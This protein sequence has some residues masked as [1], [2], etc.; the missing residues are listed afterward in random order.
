MVGTEHVTADEQ[1]RLYSEIIQRNV[2]RWG[3]D[4]HKIAKLGPTLHG[5]GII[6]LIGELVQNAED[7]RAK[8]IGFQALDAGLVVWNDGRC[9]SE[10]DV[11]AISGLLVTTKDARHIGHF[12]IGF[13]SVLLLTNCPH[14]LSG[15][16]RFSLKWALDPEGLDDSQ[17][18]SLPQEVRSLYQQGYTVFWLP[19][20]QEQPERLSGMSSLVKDK[21]GEMLLFLDSLEKITCIDRERSVSLIA[22]RL[23]FAPETYEVSIV[24]DGQ[25]K[26]TWL[27]MDWK[28]SLPEPVVKRI[29][30]QLRQED[31][32]ESAER[33]ER[34]IGT[35]QLFS[36]AIKLNDGQ[37]EPE[38][39]RV[40]VRL[41]TQQTTGLKF[42]LCGR[43]AV[44]LDR[45]GIREDDFL[46]DWA[47]EQSREV[48]RVLP[49]RLRSA[50]WFLPTMWAV[51]PCHGEVKGAFQSLEE[52]LRYELQN[53]LYYPDDLNH[54]RH[55][56]E[57]FLAH[58]SDLYELLGS[59]ELSEI[60]GVTGAR[61]V[62]PELRRGRCR[63]VI[64]NFGVQEIK[65][66]QVLNWLKTKEGK[67]FAEKGSGWLS[68]LYTYL[69]SL[70]SEDVEGVSKL[71][72]VPLQGGGV[73]EPINAF[74][75]PQDPPEP[76]RPWLKDLPIV[77]EDVIKD[78]ETREALRRLGVREF[79]VE[80]V[81]KHLIRQT[82]RDRTKPSSEE[83]RRH[84]RMLFSLWKEGRL[85]EGTLKDLSDVEFL[86]T[87]QGD[88]IA[89]KNAYLP[90]SLGGLPEVERFLSLYEEV[91]FVTDD[92]REEEDDEDDWRKFLEALGVARLPRCYFVEEFSGNWSD[93]RRWLS[94][95]VPRREVSYSTRGYSGWDWHIEGF[96]QV[97]EYLRE[98]RK[99]GTYDEDGIQWVRSLW[100]VMA[101]LLAE[102][103]RSWP[104]LTEARLKWFYRT[105]QEDDITS[106]WLHL[107]RTELWLPDEAGV[108]AKPSELI[109]PSL[110]RILG[111]GL[112]YLHREIPLQG[113]NSE[114][115]AKHLG[116]HITADL[117][118]VLNYL[119]QLAWKG[120]ME[121]SAVQ[122]VYKWLAGRGET[123]KQRLREVFAKE[124]L[125]L[126][127]GK[128]WFTASEVCWRDPTGVIPDLVDPWAEFKSFFVDTLGVRES[129][130]VAHLARFLLSLPER[131]TSPDLDM[132]REI[133]KRLADGWEKL[134]D[135]LKEALSR[136]CWLG[137]RGGNFEWCTLDR[138]FLRDK[139]WLANL[140]EGKVAWW[141]L[142]GLESLAERL[143]VLKVSTAKPVFN[144]KG[145]PQ[146]ANSDL[147]SQFVSVWR[148]IERFAQ[149]EN[150]QPPQVMIVDGISVRYSLPGFIWS[151]AEEDEAYLDENKWIL[152]VAKDA[153]SDPAHPIGDVLEK[154]LGRAGLR[155]FV[156][157]VWTAIG[158][159]QRLKKVLERWEREGGCKLL[160]LLEEVSGE[161]PHPVSSTEEETYPPKE[162]SSLS[163]PARPQERLTTPTVPSTHPSAGRRE[164]GGIRSHPT[165]SS[166]SHPSGGSGSPHEEPPPIPSYEV[167]KKAMEK[168]KEWWGQKGY[169]VEDVSGHGVGFDL[170]VWKD[171]HEFY[172]EVKGLSQPGSITMTE[173]EWEVARQRREKYFLMV[174]VLGEGKLYLIQN[175]V[176][177]L[178]VRENIRVSKE[179]V[180]DSWQEV[181]DDLEADI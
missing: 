102:H 35:H 36:I 44:K 52:P 137:R 145:S 16:F 38:E 157:D 154:V 15:N 103:E 131:S 26:E 127:Q 1:N 54:L 12:G 160:D 6:G 92:Y 93:A 144:P 148:F 72:M 173:N 155:E 126:V 97:I 18:E 74:F 150:K 77:A 58:R 69:A 146:P 114:N 73:S 27:R 143:G 79:Q 134:P 138:L 142:D 158:K 10:D 62:H 61:W 5:V 128:G 172:V 23:S 122:F 167:A 124:R 106:Y 50:G 136:S 147:S 125:I 175:P 179:Y 115:L 162:T 3:K 24:V 30:H 83:N 71:P 55:R 13:K 109:A 149:M 110:K 22:M 56:S 101:E 46:T 25:L 89:P 177:R 11:R 98:L 156:K 88:Y 42:H 31:D 39:G 121:V 65:S 104:R 120:D 90:A 32:H 40:F 181:A 70:D 123:E 48:L 96:D 53:G 100:V 95:R 41:P 176:N 99:S 94:G 105:D 169:F 119:R 43:F 168:A 165:G 152:Y 17:I 68:C 7:A 86:R 174:V 81:V 34:S 4:R 153:E 117:N 133:A 60:T 135:D 8:E 139:E 63:E 59:Q 161:G 113:K 2:E 166:V 28:C 80:L 75:P 82:Y 118:G 66:Q 140:F 51:F 129:P 171:E 76:I 130:D 164:G 64:Q 20:N 141:A 132:I 47:L 33:W 19:F 108:P 85:A 14:I 170:K 151:D 116:L 84:V 87:E 159:T 78:K 178:N 49:Q 111:E 91:A 57:V 112:R 107:L 67:W 45:T 37:P 180:I 21:A 29:A 163:T 9:F